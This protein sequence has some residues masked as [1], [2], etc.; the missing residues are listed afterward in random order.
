MTTLKINKRRTMLE[1]PTRQAGNR[2]RAIANLR[3]R[4]DGAKKEIFKIVDSISVRV[5]ANNSI[6][7]N[8]TTY[9]WDMSPERQSEVDSIIRQTIDRWLAT[10]TPERPARWFFTTYM[11][12]ATEPAAAD[13]LNNIK[14]LGEGMQSSA[15]MDAVT[16]RSIFQEPRYR[17]VIEN[18]YGRAFNEMKGFSGDTATDL[19]DA[20]MLGKSPRDAQRDIAKRFDVSDSRA[21]RIARTEINRGYTVSRVKAAK[22]VATKLDL[23]VRVLHRSSLM[24][25]TRKWHAARHGKVFTFQEQDDWWADGTNRINCLCSIAEVVVRPNGEIRSRGLAKKLEAQ[26]LIWQGLNG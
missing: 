7:N 26:R 14:L 9:I 2:R 5:S 1:D 24:I 15:E 13:A 18:I 16:L 20:V 4:L 3:K 25:S 11:S 19:N 10:Q 23:D 6:I 17:S 22:E 12:D 21:E 8:R